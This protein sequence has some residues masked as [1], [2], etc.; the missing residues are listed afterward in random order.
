MSLGTIASLSASLGVEPEPEPERTPAR[1]FMLWNGPM[2][3]SSQ[4]AQ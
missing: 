2:R 4:Y 3:I 1:H